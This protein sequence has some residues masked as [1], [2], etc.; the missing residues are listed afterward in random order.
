[1]GRRTV[2]ATL[3]VATCMALI[4]APAPVSAKPVERAKLADTARNAQRVDGLSASRRPRAGRLLALDRHGRFPTSVF[5]RLLGSS[6][7]QRPLARS[8]P[9]GQSVRGVAPD[10]TVTCALAGDITA[11]TA[12]AGLTGGGTSGEVG[13]AVAPP[14]DFSVGATTPLVDL[15]NVGSGGAISGRSSSAFATA[16]FRNLGTGQGSALQADTSGGSQGNA[17]TALNYGLDGNALR[18]ELV[19]T[20]NPKAAIFART[21]GSGQAIDAEVPA[22]GGPADA[23]YARTLSTDDSSQAGVFDGDVDIRGTLTKMDGAFRIDHPLRP[24]RAY[25]QHSFVE[26]PDMKNVYDGVVRTGARGYATVE[27]PSWFQALNGRFRYQLTAI[28]SFARAIVW[29]EV[30]RNRFTIRTSRP[31]VKVSWQVTGIRHD[32]Y[33]RAHPLAVELPK[34][35]AARGRFLAPE[36]LGRPARL[37]IDGD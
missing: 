28:R 22:G 21:S 34:R 18:A 37:R 25:L 23:L 27:L 10:G 9:T 13:L 19:N 1:M 31:G 29:R 16:W 12:G 5:A 33:A 11:V 20:G 6:L 7:V 4:A 3:G 2:K 14:L 30:R 24:A 35:G 36:E 26:S 8:C 17:I 15:E 32:A